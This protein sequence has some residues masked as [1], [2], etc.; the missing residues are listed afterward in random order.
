MH[1]VDDARG[2][3]GVFAWACKIDWCAAE[4]PASGEEI[5]DVGSRGFEIAWIHGV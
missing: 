3:V 2:G 4:E 5:V 1:E